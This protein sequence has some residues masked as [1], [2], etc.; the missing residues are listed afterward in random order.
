MLASL[1]ALLPA[2]LALASGCAL[3]QRVNA[4]GGFAVGGYDVVAYFTLDKAIRGDPKISFPFQGVIYRFASAEN[5]DLF[6]ADPIRYLPAYG[7]HSAYGVAT[8]VLAPGN[9]E[10][11][12]IYEGRLYLN[13]SKSVHGQWLRDPGGY[14]TRADANW[15]TLR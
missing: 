4:P 2:A 15:P 14:I 10:F 3:A 9:P 12:A 7:G 13:F 8:G 1:A 11:F 5:R 6:L